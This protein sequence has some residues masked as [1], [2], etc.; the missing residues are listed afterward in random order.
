M[1]VI[2]LDGVQH[3]EKEA[4]EYDAERT[5]VLEEL[6]IQVLRFTNKEVNLEFDKVKRIIHLTV[7]QRVRELGKKN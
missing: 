1:L 7:E 4:M 6:G 5:R 3:G 2:E